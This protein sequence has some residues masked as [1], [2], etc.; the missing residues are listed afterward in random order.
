MMEKTTFSLLS[1]ALTFIAF[2]PYVTSIL[3]QQTKPHVFSWFIWGC[4]TM[5]VFF[6]SWVDGAGVGAW[7]AL[8]AALI[9]FSI[10]AY[11]F[12]NRADTGISRLD[13]LFLGLA[14]SALPLWF[15]TSN[16]LWAVVIMTT[17]DLLGFGPTVRKAIEQPYSE[18]ITFFSF[19]AV[20]NIFV[21]LALE[22]YSITTIMFPAAI[23]LSCG[24]FIVLLLRL[25]YIHKQMKQEEGML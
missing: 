8:V 12:F 16:P 24:L 7:P 23:G 6:A 2:Y 4:T 13:W 21:L 17:V 5:V 19:F 18:S 15:V 9:T 14:M 25:R 11:A 22:H 10:A 20:R 3:R 1:I